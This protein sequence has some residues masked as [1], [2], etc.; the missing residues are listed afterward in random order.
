MR[1]LMAS[2]RPTRPLWQEIGVIDVINEDSSRLQLLLEMALQTKSLVAC[3]QHAL[4]DR[5]VGRV[6]DHAALT[7]SLMF[8]NERTA[9][10]GVTL[11]TGFILAEES[12]A[13]AAE[14]LLDVCSAAFHRESNVRIVAIR[15]AHSPLEHG[16]TMRQLELCPHFLVTLETGFRRFAGIVDRVRRA[17]TLH[18]QAAGPMA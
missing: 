7:Q 17:A 16:M 9:L 8:V 18:V 12:E 5:A 2:S 15:A 11:E 14:R 10:D 4:I 1:L 6:T 3:I 13:P